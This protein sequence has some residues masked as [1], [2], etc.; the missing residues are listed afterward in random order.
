MHTGSRFRAVYPFFGGFILL[1]KGKIWKDL[2]DGGAGAGGHVSDSCVAPNGCEDALFLGGIRL[3][4]KISADR[5]IWRLG[6]CMGF[7]TVSFSV[8]KKKRAKK[9]NLVD[10][11]D[12]DPKIAAGA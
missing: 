10:G 11:K 2:K 12:K 1:S 5:R 8:T 6:R 9:E 4:A 3:L 7:E